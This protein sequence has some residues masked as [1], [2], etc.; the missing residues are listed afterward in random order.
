LDS[1]YQKI[2][3]KKVSSPIVQPL[4]P[5]Q[6]RITCFRLPKWMPNDSVSGCNSCRLPFSF[7]RRKHHCRYCG[8]IFCDDCSSTR[9]P[10]PQFN[11]FTP[12]RVCESCDEV[13]RVE[14]SVEG[15]DQKSTFEV[16]QSFLQ[17][18]QRIKLPR[19]R[20]VGEDLSK[21]TGSWEVL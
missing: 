15:D 16:S 10:I 4:T 1:V 13:L 17:P 21:M 19:S 2:Q 18:P 7:F 11:F 14:N 9:Q 6:E 8:E 20:S 5:Q 12:V 3:E